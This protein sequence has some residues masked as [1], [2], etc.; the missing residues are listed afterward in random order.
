LVRPLAS[1]AAFRLEKASNR[2]AATNAGRNFAANWRFDSMHEEINDTLT[3]LRRLL[4]GD[5]INEMER[6]AVMVAIAW[7]IHIRNSEKAASGDSAPRLAQMYLLNV[8][9]PKPAS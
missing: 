1:D 3:T 9:P 4:D 7:G 2:H 6:D 5:K 8:P